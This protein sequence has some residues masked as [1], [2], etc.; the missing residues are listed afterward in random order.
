MAIGG[1]P[2]PVT[3]TWLTLLRVGSEKAAIFSRSG[4]TV[5][6]AATMSTLPLVRAGW[7]CSR[8]IGTKT[9]FTLRL[10]VL[11]SVFRSVSNCLRASYVNPRS[12]RRLSTFCELWLITSAAGSL[13]DR[14]AALP[15]PRQKND[16]GAAD[17]PRRP[18]V[19]MRHI[20]AE[21][22]LVARGK[23][24]KRR[25]LGKKHIDWDGPPVL[26][27]FPVC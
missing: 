15:P 11:S 4:V 21:A 14:P 5:T 9:T 10:P 6:I 20:S 17:L 16:E 27:D 12:W 24:A 3:T 25:Q 1:A 2:G 7:S 18:D 13:V 22:K 8:D 23:R 19:G 26:I